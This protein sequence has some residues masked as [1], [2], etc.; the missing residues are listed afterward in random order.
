MDKYSNE[1]EELK[2]QEFDSQEKTVESQE[3][4]EVENEANKEKKKDEELGNANIYL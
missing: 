3:L 1:T 2:Y 4:K